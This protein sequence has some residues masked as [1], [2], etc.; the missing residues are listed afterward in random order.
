MIKLP[1]P[2]DLRDE[3]PSDAD[4]SYDA[5]SESLLPDEDSKTSHSSQ[6]PAQDLTGTGL[7]SH[8]EKAPL[9]SESH[10]SPSSFPSVEASQPGSE[11]KKKRKLESEDSEDATKYSEGPGE[12]P[13][14]G[15]GGSL[16]RS[17]TSKGKQKQV[18]GSDSSHQGAKKKKAASGKP[19][20]E[21]KEDRER[22]SPSASGA[23][24]WYDWD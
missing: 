15:Q 12:G 7:T 18:D 2:K 10:T 11:N 22:R 21:N 1:D 20:T 24:A 6:G 9:K 23:E 4:V 17:K 3:S 14:T 13:S 5:S 19:N 16:A 8:L